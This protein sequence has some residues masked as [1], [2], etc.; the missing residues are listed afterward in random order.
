M[1]TYADV[2][3][4]IRLQRR[5]S[6]EIAHDPFSTS[7][8]C[9]GRCG[10]AAKRRGDPAPFPSGETPTGLSAKDLSFQIVCAYALRRIRFSQ[11]SMASSG[12][13][14]SGKMAF[15]HF[16][17]MIL[18]PKIFSAPSKTL[19]FDQSEYHRSSLGKN[20]K[21]CSIVT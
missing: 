2:L 4:E 20:G 8:S 18:C 12:F 7:T 6:R 19:F 16:F 21:M 11:L 10:E 15:L 1:S 3:L 9:R 5:P 14:A 13:A 17:D